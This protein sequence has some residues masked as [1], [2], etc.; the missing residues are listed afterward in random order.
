MFRSESKIHKSAPKFRSKPNYI[1]SELRS[2]DLNQMINNLCSKV[3]IWIK[4][5]VN[6]Y[7]SESKDLWTR[8]EVPIWIKWFM[9][10]AQVPIWIKRFVN[11]H[12]STDLNQMIHDLCSKVPIWI[13][14]FV[15]PHRSTD[16]NQMI[17]DLCSS[18]DLN[19]KI[20]KP[21]PKFWSKSNVSRSELCS[22]N[23][24]K[25]SQSIILGRY[26][27]VDRKLF[28]ISPG[29]KQILK[30]TAENEAKF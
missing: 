30:S 11:P 13:K 9:I 16:L 20:C 5:F 24:K 14:R 27:S 8:T 3:P 2:P 12:R 19:Q 15:N 21:A 25:D 26:K 10:C 23:L 7:R 6:P 1:R 22:P 4:T 17:H 29:L 28:S 18:S